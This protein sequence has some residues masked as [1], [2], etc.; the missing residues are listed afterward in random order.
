MIYT[1]HIDGIGSQLQGVGR[2]PDGRAVFVPGA[3]PGETVNAQITQDKGRFCEASLCAVMEV[4]PDRVNPDCPQ[5]GLCG[6]CQGR[7]MRYERTLKLKAQI[8]RDALS[9]IGGVSDPEVLPTLGCA[10]PN[11]TRNK[12]EYPIAPQD[13]EMVI[14]A[15][16]RGSRSIIPLE[17]CLLQKDESVRALRAVA[18]CLHLMGGARHLKYLVTR[19]SRV[20]ELMLVFC[21][22]APILPE[23]ERLSPAL[24]KQLPK[25]VSL[26]F[27]QLNRRPTHALDGRCT[28]VGGKALLTDRLM[29]LE[30]ELSPQ[31]FFR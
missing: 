6:G 5:T 13:E 12:A 21:A 18:E 28:R 8:V 2:L 26:F 30:F 1:I 14:G 27:C 31:A 24:F 4:S 11:R 10:D 15:Y 3:I 9:R 23:I 7:H 20:G 22:D 16:A 19:I 25:L 29:G 17:D